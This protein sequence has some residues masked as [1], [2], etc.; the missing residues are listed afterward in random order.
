M[1]HWSRFPSDCYDHCWISKAGD[2]LYVTDG[3][4]PDRMGRWRVIL[5]GKNTSG[6]YPTEPEAVA[7]AERFMNGHDPMLTQEGMKVLEGI[8]YGEYNEY[9]KGQRAANNYLRRL[10]GYKEGEK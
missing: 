7:A 4:D 10:E 6:L 1:S 9:L 8:A 2:C 3:D 5:A